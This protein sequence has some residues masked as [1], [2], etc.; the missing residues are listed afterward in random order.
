MSIRSGSIEIEF[1]DI[2]DRGKIN[3]NRDCPNENKNKKNENKKLNK[4]IKSS[5]C[6]LNFW[7][8]PESLFKLH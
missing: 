6:S 5:S 1:I 2:D 4:A 3:S 7:K 8:I